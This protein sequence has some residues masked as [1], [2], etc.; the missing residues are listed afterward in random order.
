[1][2]RQRSIDV[3]KYSRSWNYVN[4]VICY[5]FPRDEHL[6]WHARYSSVLAYGV[7]PQTVMYAQRFTSKEI[8]NRARI[9][10]DVLVCS[11]RV[12]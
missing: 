11:N 6:R 1:M 3:E 9:G 5:I 10:G 12:S 8:D 4:S 2:F 7:V